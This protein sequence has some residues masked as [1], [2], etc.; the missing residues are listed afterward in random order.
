MNSVILID[1]NILLR[2]LLQDHPLL[3]PKAR[4]IF[5]LA[6]KGKHLIYIDEVVIAETISIL[7]TYYKSAK[8][9]VVEKISKLL[10]FPWIVNSR[11]NLISEALNLFFESPKLSYIDY[12]LFVL[13]QEKSMLV[14]V[15]LFLPFLTKP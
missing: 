5:L 10:Y 3:S 2:Y 15:F 9:L 8:K 6:Q 14:L 12:W 7:R 1:T 4:E 13:S 11:K